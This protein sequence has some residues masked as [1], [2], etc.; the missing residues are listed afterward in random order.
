M[1][2]IKNVVIASSLN[3]LVWIWLTKWAH[4]S[5]LLDCLYN[6]V[7]VEF[8]L[9]FLFPIAIFDQKSFE[10]WEI[11]FVQHPPEISILAINQNFYSEDSI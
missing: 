8:S 3:Y 1:N 6:Y 11:P 2:G 5:S 4:A 7:K 9:T 10:I